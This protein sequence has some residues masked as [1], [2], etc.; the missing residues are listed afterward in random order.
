MRIA[1]I[2]SPLPA[3]LQ[4]PDVCENDYKDCENR[5]SDHWVRK[6]HPDKPDNKPKLR[7]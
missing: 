2:V 4:L 3:V 1:A 7:R 6:D 5:N